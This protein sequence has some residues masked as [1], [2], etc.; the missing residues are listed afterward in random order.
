LVDR[1][2][3][4][5]PAATLSERLSLTGAFMKIGDLVY[6]RATDWAA[7]GAD[8]FYARIKDLPGWSV[9][10]ID[11]GHDVMLDRPEE[12]AAILRTTARR[13]GGSPT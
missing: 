6:I 4:D 12:L 1:L 2:C 5:H 13:V 11:C 9:H 3:T 10:D 8:I 7:S